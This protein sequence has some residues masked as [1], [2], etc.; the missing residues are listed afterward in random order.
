ML[1]SF[2]G[3]EGTRQKDGLVRP[4][5]WECDFRRQLSKLMFQQDVDR[6]TLWSVWPDGPSLRE[7]IEDAR[8]VLLSDGLPWFT[9]LDRLDAMLHRAN[10]APEL[11][12]D[13]WGVGTSALR[14]VSS[15][16]Q[17]CKPPLQCDDELRYFRLQP[18][19]GK[20]NDR[21]TCP[22]SRQSDGPLGATRPS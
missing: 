8:R 7:V 11:M 18:A 6:P 16:W 5:E 13:T 22:R 4:E 14:S 9:E 20:P 15:S 2:I 12:T 17:R 10:T 21:Q 3:P 19:P 1:D